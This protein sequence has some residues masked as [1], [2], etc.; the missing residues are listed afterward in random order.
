MKRLSEKQRKAFCRVFLQSMDPVRAAAEIG[1]EDGYGLLETAEV[2]NELERMRAAMD[3]ELKREDVLRGLARLAFSGA[4]GLS[5]LLL[6]EEGGAEKAALNAVSEI[7]RN[8]NGTVE[9]KMVDRIK[10]L[11]TLYELLGSGESEGAEDFF[12]ALEEAGE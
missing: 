11:A 4:E 5:G 12:R 3:R 1:A 10:A 9:V 6:A 2:K 7:R 8:A